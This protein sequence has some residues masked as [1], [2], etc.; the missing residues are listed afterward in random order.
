MIF[1][2]LGLHKHF[3]GGVAFPN[4]WINFGPGILAA[5]LGA[6]PIFKSNTMWFGNQNLRGIMSIDDI[7]R[8]DIDKNNVWWKR[9]VSAT[10][11]AVSRH[12]GKFIVGMT[13]IG[14]VL[15]VIAALRGTVE[16][17]K[18]MYFNANKL[19]LAIENVTDIWIRCY[20]ELYNIMVSTGHEGSSAWMGIWCSGGGTQY[21][22][23]YRT[24]FHQ[25]TSKNLFYPI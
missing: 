9:V 17:V 10:K 3:F 16:V 5:W 21:N 2:N 22:A 20:N 24:C 12:H 1:L 6:Q 18:D 14:G 7:A 8:V 11:V 19:I 23:I 15:D 13:D 4:L 25:N